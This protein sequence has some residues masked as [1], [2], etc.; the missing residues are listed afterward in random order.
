MGTG[1]RAAWFA[2]LLRT[3]SDPFHKAGDARATRK[4]LKGRVMRLRCPWPRLAHD[5]GSRA[6][7]VGPNEVFD[8]ET[9][10]SV[11]V[12]AR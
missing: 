4:A 8:G 2:S 3:S 11:V 10:S 1:E 12:D 9:T 7:T 6:I 5:T